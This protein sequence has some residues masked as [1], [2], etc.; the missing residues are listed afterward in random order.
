[1]SRNQIKTGKSRYESRARRVLIPEFRFQKI[2]FLSTHH[3]GNPNGVPDYVF[4]ADED[5]YYPN[6]PILIQG[7]GRPWRIGNLYL[8]NKLKNESGYESRTFR[9]IADHL[10]DY[11]RFLEDE[12]LDYL[13]LP[14]NDRLKVTFRY[15]RRLEE[16]LRNGELSASNAK[17]RINAVVNFYRE[18]MNW[19][20]VDRSLIQNAPFEEV[21]RHITVTSQYG[22]Q[23][24]I[25]IK[26][27]NLTI[28][29]PKKQ[30][31]SD[32]INDGGE[33]RPLT[34]EDQ[35]SVLKALLASSR[36]YQLMFYF[37]LFTGARIQTVGT[38]RVKHLKGKMDG[39]GDL[40]L[41]IGH[42]TEIDTK[43]GKPMQLLVPEWLVKDM[44]IYSRSPEAIKRRERSFYGDTED[45][46]VFLSR[47]GIPYYTSKKEIYDRRDASVSRK[48]GMSDR[49][50]NVSIQDGASLRQHI[51]E[52]LLPRIYSE[53]PSFQDFTFHD[54]RASFG[55]N[56][57]ESQLKHM[58]DQ[59]ITAALEYV[60][61][62]M[63]HSS[64]ETTMQYLNYKSRLQWKNSVQHEF[65]SQLFKHVNTAAN[66]DGL[67]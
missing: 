5:G 54:L 55:M 64:K 26:S 20:L 56:L 67:V 50:L 10:L 62:R 40:R 47:N 9:G 46:Y 57:L 15:K 41:P 21:G 22:I 43:R 19:N 32:Y 2:K 61:Q 66:A 48:A 51:R 12:Q 35:E 4:S 38:M 58:G 16:Q 65:E 59:R 24:S 44:L 6:F 45:N 60:Q 17:A 3:D 53:N 18:I 37:A 13:C 25:K 28:S 34:V 36:E 30:R 23:N 31:Q 27:H 1:M 42:G 39:D 33:L 52:I 49:A 7:D 14:K 63:G 11:L 8:T 29:T